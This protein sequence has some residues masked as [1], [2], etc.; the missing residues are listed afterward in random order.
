MKRSLRNLAVPCGMLAV[1]YVHTASAQLVDYSSLESLVGEPVTINATG[2][3]QRVQDVA[4][5]MTIITADQIRESGSRNIPEILG[6]VPGL[7]ILHEGNTTYDVGVRG[8]QQAMSSRLLVLIDGRQAFADDYSRTIWENLAV[9][10][11]DIRQ[12][13]VVKG[14]SSALFG[15]NAS[16]GV[17]NIV[18]YNPLYDNNNVATVTYG[19]QNTK[20]A[21]AT[22]TG[23]ISPNTGV[24]ISAGGVMAHEFATSRLQGQFTEGSVTRN[25]SER[26]LVASAVSQ[27]APDLLG[28]LEFTYAR[29]NGTEA[30]YNGQLA[31]VGNET[32]S[33]RG[34]SSWQTNFG[35]IK[36]NIYYNHSLV[37]NDEIS[38]SLPHYEDT[39][40]LV[41]AELEDQFKIGKDHTF[42]IS[43][44]YQHKDFNLD[45]PAAI[46]LNTGVSEN[47][48]ALSGMWLWQVTDK[49]SWVN[50]L[51]GDY[52]GINLD[53]NLYPFET[54]SPFSYNRS[55]REMS[56]NSGFVY[57]ATD[58]DTFRLN[59]GRGAQMPSLLD[60]G[61]NNVSRFNIPG[62][63][64]A[65]MRQGNPALN[66]T[67][68]SNYE[69]GY[70]RVIAPIDSTAKFS[71]FYQTNSSIIAPFPFITTIGTPVSAATRIRQPIDVGDSQG[72]G[73]EMQL[74]GKND[75]GFRWDAS[76]SYANVI[77]DA[78]VLQTFGY[79]NSTP[80]HHFRAL[81][82][83]TYDNWEFDTNTQYLTSRTLF[84]LNTGRASSADYVSLGGRIGYKITDGITA[85]LSATE[86]NN[87]TIQESPYP[88]IERQLYLSL[89]ARF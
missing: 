59:Y 26:Y 75:A 71:V 62:N 8:Y 89:T 5:N 2:T 39:S 23:K 44:Q 41:S 58:L 15:S 6:R 21:D 45:A 10:I 60:Y 25:P 78:A 36:S 24:K 55:L 34:G 40:N 67:T 38:Q 13:E 83:Y 46:A 31:G 28:N 84:R 85:A 61:F 87:E 86:L 7:D 20:T 14:A 68:A 74:L 64:G 79:E 43:T 69:A 50:A 35:T 48:F 66:P 77:D 17:V 16:G 70:D 49:L 27:L 76:Y 80:M 37:S 33:L 47:N 72:F 12:I 29:S 54:I 57:Q 1:L 73:G 81:L 19:T 52:I 88:A 4:T 9:N 22:V 82:G 18:T 65:L 51:R 30:Y 32:Y 11:D 56:A 63:T 53:G 3:P 42:R